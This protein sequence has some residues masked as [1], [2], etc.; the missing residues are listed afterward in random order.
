MNIHVSEPSSIA[1][2]VARRT[3]VQE[4]ACSNP[5]SATFVEIDHETISTTF[6]RLPLIQE[7][8]I[9]VTGESTCTSTVDSRYLDLAYL[10][11][12]LITK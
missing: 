3:T 12:P 5:S 11:Y 9:S 8:K 2:S 4:I 1:Q 10:E 6:L 7:G